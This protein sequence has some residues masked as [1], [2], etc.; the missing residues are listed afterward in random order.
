MLISAGLVIYNV[1]QIN[2]EAPLGKGSIEAVITS[3]AGLCAILM[4]AILNV[5]KKIEQKVK[6][7]H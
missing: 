3:I 5:S 2:F 1:T 6:Q 4:L 7:N